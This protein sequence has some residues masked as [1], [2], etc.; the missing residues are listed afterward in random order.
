M[1]AR[2]TTP[3]DLESAIQPDANKKGPGW[4]LLIGGGRGPG[5]HSSLESP[6]TSRKDTGRLL[7]AA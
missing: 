7:H 4:A 2:S 3:I 1:A 5:I 6:P